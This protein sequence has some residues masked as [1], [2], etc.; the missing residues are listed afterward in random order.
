MLGLWSQHNGVDVEGDILRASDYKVAGYFASVIPLAE[1]IN[2]FEVKILKLTGAVLVVGLVS[3]SYQLDEPPGYVPHSIGYCCYSG[4]FHDGSGKNGA[5]VSTG[6]CETGDVI[7]C[8]IEITQCGHFK[9]KTNKVY[10][11]KNGEK[12]YST[13]IDIPSNSSGLYPAIRLLCGARVQLLKWTSKAENS[14]FTANHINNDKLILLEQE[15]TEKEKE[16][17]KYK[18]KADDNGQ[19]AQNFREKVAK[20]EN[21]RIPNIQSEL[22]KTKQEIQN[23]QRFV[24]EKEEEIKLYKEKVVDLEN[25]L[26]K[27]QSK[28]TALDEVNKKRYNEFEKG[29]IAKTMHATHFQPKDVLAVKSEEGFLGKGGFGCVRLGFTSALGAIAIK[30]LPLSGSKQEIKE[31]RE[32]HMREIENLKLSSH[33][34]VV[35]LEGFT[36]WHGA[37]GLIMEYL[38]GQSLR[39]LILGKCLDRFHVPCIPPVIKL[40]ICTD[41]ASGITFLHHGFNDQRIT[42]GD[43]KPHNV[44]LTSDLRC[45][46]SDLGEADFATCT[47]SESHLKND[48]KHAMTKIYAAPELLKNRQVRVSKA[49]DVYSFGMTVRATLIRKHP[50]SYGDET[51]PTQKF[52]DLAC[53]AWRPP[54]DDVEDLTASLTDEVDVA[55][56]DLLK[57]EMVK[58][59]EHNPDERPSMM[60]VRD[61]LLQCLSTK[62]QSVI[63]QHVADITKHM[64]IKLPCQHQYDCA[65]IDQFPAPKFE[66]KSN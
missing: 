26:K 9:K 41:V 29:Q 38:P 1:R 3:D 46:I 13:T 32:K 49:M 30:C 63:A 2:Y 21:V 23:L 52:V 8:G 43:L 20:L 66:W 17:N 22:N 35:R 24:R 45:K 62:D 42:H 11:T 5:V 15:N 55:I 7:G 4:K 25:K 12:F 14:N 65:K 58:C 64:D 10:F 40:R 19:E 27:C 39:D 47:E 61:R 31:S 50:N 57:V 28:I 56:I 37:A 44:L 34:N 16:I 36:D 48:T 6:T 33:V 60:D 51:L 54:L 53:D 18:R 59:W